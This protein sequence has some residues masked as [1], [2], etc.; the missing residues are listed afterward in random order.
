MFR[1]PC[2]LFPANYLH[3]YHHGDRHRYVVEVPRSFNALHAGL[4]RRWVRRAVVETTRTSLIVGVLIALVARTLS[5]TD[6]SAVSTSSASLIAATATATATT[7]AMSA[8]KAAALVTAAATASSTPFLDGEGVELPV[9]LF[10]DVLVP[11]VWAVGL[12]VVLSKSC[13]AFPS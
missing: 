5:P 4:H 1:P 3:W 8:A 10:K 6:L 7:K 2:W 12:I 13:P 11:H 9:G